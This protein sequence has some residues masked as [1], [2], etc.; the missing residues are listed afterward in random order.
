[1]NRISFRDR[2]TGICANCEREVPEDELDRFRWCG[3]C[4]RVVV[5]RAS[6]WARIIGIAAAALLATW[7]VLA[8]SPSGRFLVGW[9]AIIAATYY[10]SFKISRRVAFDLIRARGITPPE[11]A[12]EA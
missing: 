7:I 5:R 8:I 12:D 3:E 6:V 9:M 4:R 10:L 1:V 11:G 2:D